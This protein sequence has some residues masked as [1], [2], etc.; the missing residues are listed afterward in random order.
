MDITI[1]QTYK[2]TLAGQPV[3]MQLRSLKR[4]A[5]LKLFPMMEKM[6]AIDDGESVRIAITS[7]ELQE[8]AAEILP[9]HVKNLEGFTVDGAAP[10]IEL[11]TEEA[12]FSPLVTE[13]IGRLF[14][15][16]QLTEEDVKNSDGPSA[17]NP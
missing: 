3:V 9:E 5:A 15:I 7:M 1:W 6:G 12:I 13:I 2:T 10:S 14:T 16:S 8:L 11:I 17:L 4:G